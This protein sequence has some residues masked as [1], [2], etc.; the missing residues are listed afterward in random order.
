MKVNLTISQ[1]YYNVSIL[2]F[3]FRTQ[4]KND[5]NKLF[6]SV[7]ESEQTVFEAIENYSDDLDEIEELFYNDS[8]EEICEQLRLT[9]IEEDEQNDRNTL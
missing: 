4:A 2:N 7:N 1:L 5:F 6:E 3:F 8:I 9:L